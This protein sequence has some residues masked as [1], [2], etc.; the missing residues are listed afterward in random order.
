MQM[1]WLPEGVST[2]APTID[3][4]FYIILLITGAVFVLVQGTLLYCVVRYRRRHGRRATYTHGNTAVEIIWTLIPALILI[5]LAVY[6]QNVWSSIRGTPPP[7]DLEVKITGEQF[8][9]NIQYPGAD[10]TFDT[11]D[12]PT[13][14]NQLHIPVHQTVLIHLASKD[15]IHSFF[16]PQF[17]VKQDAVPGLTGRLWLSATKTGHFEIACAELCG[18]GHYRMRGFLTIESPEEFAAWLADT[19]AE[20]AL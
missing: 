1:I 8:A 19:L 15:V 12:D 16:V 18:L 20:R 4:L 9:W 13:T 7:H 11:A 10:G 14:L 2:Y 17:R 6:S 5:G 3:R